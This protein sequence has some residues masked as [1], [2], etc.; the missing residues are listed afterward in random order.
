MNL[1]AFQ[2]ANDENLSPQLSLAL[3]CLLC[4][5]MLLMLLVTCHTNR[6]ECWTSSILS[7]F[8][9]V[10]SR[11]CHVMVSLSSGV[12]SSLKA[13]NLPQAC[14]II[15]WIRE[16]TQ[17]KSPV[18]KIQKRGMISQLAAQLPSRNTLFGSAGLISQKRFR[19]LPR[20]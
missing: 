12:A 8:G 16:K 19:G 6:L 3:P 13:T 20:N 7:G 9:L 10:Q 18:K 17:V 15:Q 4:V 11:S 14:G 5:L 1:S 2:W